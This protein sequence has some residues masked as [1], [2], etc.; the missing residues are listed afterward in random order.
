MMLN[1]SLQATLLML[2]QQAQQGYLRLLDYQFARFIGEQSQHSGLALL[3]AAVSA[4]LGKGHICL[5]LFDELGQVCELASKIGLFGEAATELNA[6]LQPIDWR[7]LLQTSRLVGTQGEAV[8]LMFDGERV[9]LHRYWHYEVVLA[10][11][12]N[13]LSHG[14]E[15]NASSAASLSALLDR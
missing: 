3:A 7:A 14:I 13:Q 8:P 12:L 5:P 9:Y 15:L 11:K 10:Q 1:G 2:E 6:Q 4:E